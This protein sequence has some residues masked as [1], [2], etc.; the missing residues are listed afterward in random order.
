[1]TRVSDPVQYY[2]SQPIKGHCRLQLSLAI[3]LIVIG[4]NVTKILRMIL[5]LRHQKS[6]PLVTRGNAIESF[7]SERDETTT[8]M[9]LA[10]KKAFFS[11]TWIPAARIYAN[12]HHRWFSS[13]SL[14]HW[15]IC[16]ILCIATLISASGLLANGT[17]IINLTFTKFS[18]MWR[19]GYGAVTAESMVNLNLFGD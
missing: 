14:K 4:C 15:L 12:K 19:M 1:M 2:L 11:K 17:K 8:G 7:L 16:N 18:Y 10:D 5:I 9:C 6:P 13:A 3:M